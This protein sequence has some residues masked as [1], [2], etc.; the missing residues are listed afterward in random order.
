MK[1]IELKLNRARTLLADRAAVDSLASYIMEVETSLCVLRPYIFSSQKSRQI[2]LLLSNISIYH[3]NLR[4]HSLYGIHIL[5]LL[6][7]A[8]LFPDGKDPNSVSLALHSIQSWFLL[9]AVTV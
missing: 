6:R 2:P 1:T 3:N 5:P 9:K 4:S 7:V 8:V